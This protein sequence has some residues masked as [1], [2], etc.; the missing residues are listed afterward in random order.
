MKEEKIDSKTIIE[1][2][3]ELSLFN[4]KTLDIEEFKKYVKKKNEINHKLFTF[5]EKYI[6]RKLKLNGYMNRL[7]SEQ[8]MINQF[9]KT[10]GSPSEVIVNF[11]DFE[12]KRHMKFKE[13]IKGVGIRKLFRKNGYQT[14]L[15][16]EFRT[17]C[18]YS[19]CEKY[20]I[21][22]NPKPFKN[23]LRLVHGAIRCKTCLVRWNRDCNGATNIYKIT[24]NAINKKLRPSYLTRGNTSGVLD[25]TLKT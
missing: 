17:S 8:K 3:T 1:Y 18:R 23:N 2:E 11:G 22:E 6:F 4:K 15:V 13:P 14:F 12:Q 16:D 5:Y 9:K 10:F 7:K 24:K 21:R 20:I 19:K 25:D